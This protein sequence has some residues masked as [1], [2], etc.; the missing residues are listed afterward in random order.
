M[1]IATFHRVNDLTPEELDFL[2][3]HPLPTT[4]K[5]IDFN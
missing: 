2:R 1:S 5:S 4:P 3:P